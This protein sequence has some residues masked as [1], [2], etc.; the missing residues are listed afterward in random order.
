MLLSKP[1]KSISGLFDRFYVCR[2]TLRC[3]SIDD[4]GKVVLEFEMEVCLIP[5]MEMIGI[6]ECS[7]VLFFTHNTVFI[8]LSKKVNEFLNLTYSQSTSHVTSIS[9]NGMIIKFLFVM[10]GI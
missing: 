5:K 10:S 3:K 4:R 1:M 6:Q 8:C 9:E 2:Y 7:F